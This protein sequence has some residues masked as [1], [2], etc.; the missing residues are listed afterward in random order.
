MTDAR[1]LRIS[2]SL[3]ESVF[4]LRRRVIAHQNNG[5]NLTITSDSAL[6]VGSVF[7]ILS[8]IPVILSK[9]FRHTLKSL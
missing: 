8:H 9:I 5:A 6:I 2:G 4:L 7:S 1:G 3:F